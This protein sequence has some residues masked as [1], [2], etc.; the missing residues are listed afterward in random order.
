VAR[1]EVSITIIKVAISPT[2]EFLLIAAALLIISW[3]IH[4]RQQRQKLAQRIS[5][6]QEKLHRVEREVQYREVI[7]EYL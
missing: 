1:S 2:I 4:S 6:L 5:E 7:R 3:A